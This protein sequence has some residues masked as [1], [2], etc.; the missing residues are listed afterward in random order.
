MSSR[1]RYE[2]LPAIAQPGVDGVSLGL[3]VDDAS[4]YGSLAVG[5]SGRLLGFHE[6]R[7]GRGLING[8]VYFF[9][10]RALDRFPRMQPLSME[11]DVFPALLSAGAD[12]RVEGVQA[13]FLDIG[14]PESVRQAE[15]FVQR[16]I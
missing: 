8:G 14:T 4:R 7:P 11:T 9:R 5:E 1:R 15:G 12:L 16:L 10:Q 13:P 6:K 2:A 3:E